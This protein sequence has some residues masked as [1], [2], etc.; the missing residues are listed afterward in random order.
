MKKGSNKRRGM[1]LCFFFFATS[2]TQSCQII[3]NAELCVLCLENTSHS[4][5]VL[6]IAL[7]CQRMDN[8]AF[9]SQ[10]CLFPL[11]RFRV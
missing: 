6:G 3:D 1:L 11:L 8:I 2:S 9:V 5:K 10:F 7:S 4:F